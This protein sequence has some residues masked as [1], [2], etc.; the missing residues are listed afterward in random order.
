TPGSRQPKPLYPARFRGRYDVRP[1]RCRRGRR[2][3]LPRSSR[4]P[5]WFGRG[6][7]LAD[8]GHAQADP[9]GTPAR[10]VGIAGASPAV[11]EDVAVG[12]EVMWRGARDRRGDDVAGAHQLLPRR[13]M[14][15]PPVAGTAAHPRGAAVLAAFSGGDQ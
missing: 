12:D 9:A 15:Q 11:V 7:G 4:A 8:Y 14:H 6:G 2:R 13:E 5:E 3:T 1:P 10:G